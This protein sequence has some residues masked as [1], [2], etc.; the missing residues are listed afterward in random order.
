MS[1]MC[2]VMSRWIDY[3]LAWYSYRQYR[4]QI[5]QQEFTEMAWQAIVSSPEVAR[6]NKHQIVETE[7]LMKA[8]HEQKKGLARR[9][10]SKAGVDNTRLLEATDKFIQCQPRVTQCSRYDGI[11]R[12]TVNYLMLI[13]FSHLVLLN[14]RLL[15]SQWVRCWAGFGKPDA[16]S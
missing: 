16:E 7:H 1:T 11:I 13:T 14:G 8:L 9:I 10:F 6:E 15:V 2:F 3:F 12:L 4:L 5:T